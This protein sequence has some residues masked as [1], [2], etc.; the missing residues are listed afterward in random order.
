LTASDVALDSKGNLYIADDDN[1]RIRKV[2]KD[3]IIHTVAGS[4]KEGNSGDG[5]P[6][7]KA[8]LNEP[9]SIDFDGEGNLFILC[10]RTSVVRKVDKNGTITTIAG[11]S[12]M[13]GVNREKGPATKVWLNEPIGPFFDD[14]SGVLYIGD[15]FNSRIRA[16]DLEGS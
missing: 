9:S 4:G 15:T 12:G 7:T 14:D 6:A 16:V 2:D 11:T 8:A 5:G 1:H 10:H 13:Q 3:G